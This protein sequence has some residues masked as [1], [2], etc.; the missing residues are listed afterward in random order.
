[1]IQ[2]FGSNIKCIEYPTHVL[3]MFKVPVMHTGELFSYQW[4]R[5]HH[6]I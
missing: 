6:V 4:S 3:R 5:F 2:F 1:M